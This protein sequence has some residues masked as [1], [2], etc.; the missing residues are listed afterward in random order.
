MRK[1]SAS[2]LIT[3]LFIAGGCM[4]LGVDYIGAPTMSEIINQ[5]GRVK[6]YK[7]AL[8]G[9]PGG[10]LLASGM[11]GLSPDNPVLLADCAYM[12][13]AY[14]LFVEDTDP[15]HAKELFLAGKAYGMQALAQDSMFRQGRKEGVP[16]HELVKKMGPDQAPA[17]CWAGLNTGMWVMLNLDDPLALLEMADATAM[18]RQADR[19]DGTY[20]HGV[21]KAFLGCYYA[22]VP[23]AL[24]PD[25]GPENAAKMFRAARAV[26]DGHMLLIDLFEARF[27]AAGTND[28]RRFD[29]LLNRILETDA[30]ALETGV[31]FNELAKA[32]ARYYLDHR[33][34]YL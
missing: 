27:L 32:K 21:A 3:F 19:L 4:K 20:F 31:L 25:C 7:L 12:Y 34:L 30:S 9:L 10:I 17:L 11:A 15:D 1:I 6:S 2:I 18:V 33:H 13:F 26:D 28:A 29:F 24:D 5:M 8:E 22:M 14:G 16:V 23:Q